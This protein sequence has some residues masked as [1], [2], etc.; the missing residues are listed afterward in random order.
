MNEVIHNS[1]ALQPLLI[2]GLM[3]AIG[4]YAGKSMK[5]IKLPSIIG[6]MIIGVALGPSLFNLLDVD[7]QR[8]LSFISDVALSFVAV[9]I[10][11]ELSFSS[12][13]KQGKGII[14]VIFTESFLAFFFVSILLYF[15][16]K[17]IALSIV[18]GAIAPAS[19]PAGT[20]AIIQEYKAKGPLTKAL[21][22][23]VGFDDGL[24]IVIFG[25]AAAIAKSILG[26]EAGLETGNWMTLLATPLQEILFSVLVGLALSF[27]YT[28]L[29]RK[30]KSGRDMFI[31]MFATI[32]ISSGISHMLHLSLILTNMIIGIYI[33]NTQP[34]N[35][36]EKIH[37]ELS[38]F[39]PL[40]F[41]MFFVL[42]GANL[43]V[44]AIP[45]LGLIGL[46]YIIGRTSG[47]MTG[48]TLGAS[49]G[50]LSPN[51]KKYLGMGILSQ[52]G[53]AIGLALIVKN[54]F[55]AYGEHGAYI[56][57]VVITTVTATSLFFEIIG[58]ILTK[59]GLEK[60]GEIKTT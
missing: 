18:F 27:L 14:L 23:V 41:V 40:L 11:L 34:F 58:P 50:K 43:H 19:A 1:P 35:L 28:I 13:K 47:L 9:S 2:V 52:A 31:L 60:A 20:V 42:A 44:S 45:S 8:N 7:F 33:V 15:L 5:Y 21:Y 12:L 4:F 26:R 6:F 30:L 46:V 10:G 22:S 48:A 3:V 29:A 36:V 24:G 55:A 56:G 37:N 32:L 54:E 57:G 25:F 51:I 17:D 53:V 39:M 38:E 49:L 16:T 59:I